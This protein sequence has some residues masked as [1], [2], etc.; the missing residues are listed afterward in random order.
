MNQFNLSFKNLRDNQVKFQT[1]L[2][3]IKNLTKQTLFRTNKKQLKDNKDL[4]FINK[5]VLV[6]RDCKR[7]AYKI[8][9]RNK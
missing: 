9:K 3:N 6:Y 5:I 8:S 7:M 1:L 2:S 4:Q